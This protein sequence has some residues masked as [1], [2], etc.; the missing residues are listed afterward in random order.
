MAMPLVSI[1]RKICG[2]WDI[3]QR[4]S[5][6]ATRQTG[7]W[8]S[9][10]ILEYQKSSAAPKACLA[11]DI[12][13]STGFGWQPELADSRFIF[14][15]N[16]PPANAIS[17]VVGWDGG[18]FLVPQYEADTPTGYRA[19]HTLSKRRGRDVNFTGR[20]STGRVQL[21]SWGYR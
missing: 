7:L 5:L 1:R 8:G 6:D 3:G 4:N 2:C 18:R 20:G 13:E 21:R 12:G 10:L 9:F 15:K 14:P 11:G 16:S 19:A 17:V